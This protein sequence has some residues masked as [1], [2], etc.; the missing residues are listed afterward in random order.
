[1]AFVKAYFRKNKIRLIS[2]CVIS[3]MA[4]WTSG[5]DQ[6]KSKQGKA[7]ELAEKSGSEAIGVSG[8]VSKEYGSP[9]HLA[10]LEDKAID[11]SSGIIASRR[12]AGIFWT[13]NDSG[14]GPFLYAFDREGNRRGTWRVAGAD[15]YDWE[16]IAI[17]PGP[18]NAQSYLY[19]GDIGDN[20]GDRKELIVYR[21][22]EP[23]V[24]G[25]DA[26]ADRFST[27][28][29][30]TAEAI[31]LRYPQGRHNAESLLVH[32][33]TGDIY[34]I[35]K[36]MKPDSAAG[37]FKL[38]APYSTAGVN[39]LKLVSELRVPHMFQAMI[40]AGDISPDGQR[41]VLCDYLSAYELILPERS[42]FDDIWKQTPVRISLGLRLHGEAVCY[43]HDGKAILATSE[44][45]PTPLIEVERLNR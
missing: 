21:V 19:I 16:G 37:V 44:K 22:P 25:S 3:L 23:V 10:D 28:R 38:A 2:L 18:D 17:G 36:K 41:V 43:R 13:H 24:T 4:L 11:E 20:G 12:N 29:T 9:V 14:D 7:E 45:Q 32:P 26:G 35:T 42:S 34:I 1:L 30:Q 31:R 8:E 39:T 33:T 5:C 40:T 27:L 15:A 6:A